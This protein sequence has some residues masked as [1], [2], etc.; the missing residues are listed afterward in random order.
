[1][2]YSFESVRAKVQNK[3]LETG[4][5]PAIIYQRYL[6]ERF[7]DRIAHS[8]HRNSIIIK[9]GMLVSAI[10]G[11]DMR[12]TKDLDATVIGSL[13]GMQDWDKYRTEYAYAAE[14]EF[15]QIAS[16][17]KLLFECAYY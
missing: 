10:A 8:K 1:V 17:R 15:K 14:I 3:C 16:A 4:I 12:A 9:G 13:L 5:K 7:I 2:N 11:V 6:L